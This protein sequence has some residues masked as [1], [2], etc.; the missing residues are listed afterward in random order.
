MSVTFAEVEAAAARLAG[1][2][3][4]TP[5]IESPVLNERAGARV[6]IKPETLYFNNTVLTK[7][8][9]AEKWLIP[10]KDSWLGA[11]YSLH[12]QS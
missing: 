10:V 1:H 8:D 9:L 5:L 7:D 11:R 12:L 6:L 2:A 3:A 4:A